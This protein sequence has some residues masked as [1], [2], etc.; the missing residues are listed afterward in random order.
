VLINITGD[1]VARCCQVPVDVLPARVNQHVM[2][3]RTRA[4]KLDARYLAYQLTGPFFQST[5]LSIAGSGGTRKAL[6]KAM[7]ERLEVPLPKIEQQRQ[8]AAILSVY[9]D[10]IENN[11]R[12]IALLEEAARQ[13]Y[14]E[15]FVR[16]RFPGH[17]HVEIVDGVPEGWARFPFPEIVDFKEGPGLRNYQYRDEGIPFINI[18][19]LGNGDID[20]AKTQFLDPNEVETK[21]RHFLV[22]ENDHVVSSSGT[23]GRVATV[24]KSHLPLCLNT[25]IIR[26]RPRARMGVW[27]LRAYLS[28]G[29]FLDQATARATGAAQLNFGPSHLKQMD[30]LIP[31]EMLAETA[32]EELTPIFEQINVLN[33]QGLGLTKAR[34]LLLPKLMSGAI[35]V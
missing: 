3:I 22:A 29:D 21:Y 12:R 1:S 18:R 20:L 19:T 16:F 11:R 35:A 13:L 34:N 28:H 17:E 27:L 23:L 8:I 6:T 31:T 24:R 33:D 10:L 4:D 5:L 25:S 30:I 9:D 14:K 2:I 15:W 7:L 26:M 32:E